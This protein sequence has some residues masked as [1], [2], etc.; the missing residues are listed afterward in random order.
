MTLK[1]LFICCKIKKLAQ[2][3]GVHPQA[4]VHSHYIFSKYASFVTHLSCIS[5]FSTG[6]KLDNFCAKKFTF[7]SL[8][9]AK[10]WLRIW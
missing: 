4:P 10:S 2:R 8:P 5:V 1:L 9:S 3:L 6:P 7:G